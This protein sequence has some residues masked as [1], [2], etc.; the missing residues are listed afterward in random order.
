MLHVWLQGVKGC[1]RN[2]LLPAYDSFPLETTKTS[3]SHHGDGHEKT[4]LN[5]LELQ[6]MIK[7]IRKREL[8]MGPFMLGL[9]KEMQAC[10]CLLVVPDHIPHQSLC[11]WAVCPWLGRRLQ[12]ELRS[13]P[14]L[15]GKTDGFQVL[16]LPIL[17]LCICS[18]SLLGISDFDKLWTSSNIFLR[19]NYVCW[20][21]S[22]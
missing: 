1:K 19:G 18:L 9:S 16:L 21:F 7:N 6:N 10:Q 13:T 20:Q 11:P 12:L 14:A 22:M 3:L 5:L 17:F 4:A 2:P 8:L 15:W